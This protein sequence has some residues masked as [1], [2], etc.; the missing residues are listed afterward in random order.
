MLVSAELYMNDKFYVNHSLYTEK[1]D[2]KLHRSES[3]IFSMCLSERTMDYNKAGKIC[4]KAKC[5][6]E[7]AISNCSFGTWSSMLCVMASAESLNRTIKSHYPDDYDPRIAHVF[8]VLLKPTVQTSS[9]VRPSMDI[10]WVQPSTKGKPNHFVPLFI[11]KGSDYST[12]TKERRSKQ[13]IISTSFRKVLNQSGISV[14]KGRSVQ[15]RKSPFDTSNPFHSNSG[16]I[17]KNPC[18]IVT[19]TDDL[20]QSPSL[21][22]TIVT[23][24]NIIQKPLITNMS[25]PTESHNQQRSQIPRGKRKITI[26]SNTPAV[27]A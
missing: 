20:D 25:I 16:N 26:D 11:T 17:E 2:S 21:S 23:N 4:D 3:S 13:S 19:S 1:F 14:Q 27:I 10:L 24:E 15:F 5:I 18:P 22:T 7:E 12:K 9:N 6:R 8:N